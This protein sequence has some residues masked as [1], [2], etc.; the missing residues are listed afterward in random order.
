[1]NQ[2]EKIRLKIN[3]RLIEKTNPFAYRIKALQQWPHFKFGTIHQYDL[4]LNK[5]YDEVSHPAS[6]L[7]F[8][9]NDF[10]KAVILF[11]WL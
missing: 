11:S 4:N 8:C 9:P 5:S 10:S 2:Y 1:M 3:C 6:F 7:Y